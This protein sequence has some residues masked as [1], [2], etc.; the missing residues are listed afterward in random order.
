MKKIR[1]GIIENEECSRQRLVN[2]INLWAKNK[3]YDIKYFMVT[4][5][6]EIPICEFV[7][8][9]IIFMDIK[10]YNGV[11]GITFAE[12]LRNQNYIGEIVFVTAFWNM[13]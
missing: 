8:M 5:D 3:H 9:N 6:K 2:C 13:L 11:N 1:V 12:Q 10:F 7:D 4:S